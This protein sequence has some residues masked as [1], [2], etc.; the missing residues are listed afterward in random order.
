MAWRATRQSIWHYL[1]ALTVA[2]PLAA[3]TEKNEDGLIDALY[4]FGIEMPDA[5]SEL[6]FWHCGNLINHESRKSIEAVAFGGRNRN[7]K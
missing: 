5:V 7:A 1:K 2:D 6:I 3:Q 4:I